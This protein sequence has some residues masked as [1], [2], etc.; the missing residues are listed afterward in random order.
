M[1]IWGIVSLDMRSEITFYG[2][3]N[4]NFKHSYPL[5]LVMYWAAWVQFPAMVWAFY[6][7]Y[8]YCIVRHNSWIIVMFINSF[9][10]SVMFEKVIICLVHLPLARIQRSASTAYVNGEM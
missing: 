3:P 2:S 4:V 5:S 8:G 6:T 1:Y 10:I 9:H 7:C